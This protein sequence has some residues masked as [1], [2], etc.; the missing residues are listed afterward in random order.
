MVDS[1]TEREIMDQP[2][3]GEKIRGDAERDAIHIAIIPV[4][5]DDDYLWP[6][7]KIRLRH[8]SHTLV[9]RDEYS[10]ESIGVVDPFLDGGVKRGEKFWCWLFPGTITGMRHH[11]Q[12][13][14]FDQEIEKTGEHEQWLRSF[15][16]RWGFHWS[17]MIENAS[18]EGEYVTAYG[19]DL[20][21]AEELGEDY[22][23]FWQHLE[24]FLNVRFSKSH[25]ESIG[26][27]CSC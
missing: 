12:H 3:I 14:A 10:E 4:I 17:E 19:Y 27:S 15:A 11:W 23:L 16:E 5:A 8:G 9:F 7:V 26:W 22:E 1:G 18:E 13:P 25:R 21:S 20:H 24:G 2:K 6:G